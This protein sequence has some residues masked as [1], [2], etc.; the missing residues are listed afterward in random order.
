MIENSMEKA[1][2]GAQIAGETAASLKDI[3]SGINESS[4]FIREIAESSEEQSVGISHINIGI[5]Q[6]A[7]V[8]QQNSATAEESAAASQELTGQSAA[9]SDLISRF[10]LRRAY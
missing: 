7:Q 2:L 8:V 3:V 4:R 10:K 1:T 9:L 6:V 5:E